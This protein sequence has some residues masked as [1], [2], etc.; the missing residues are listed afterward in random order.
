MDFF[1][2]DR[3][4]DDIVFE[5]P[6]R[7]ANDESYDASLVDQ[8]RRLKPGESILVGPEDP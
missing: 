1:K 4:L 8:L 7:K 6:W 5:E 2:G 3:S